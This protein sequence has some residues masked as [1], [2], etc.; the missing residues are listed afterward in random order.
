MCLTC[1]RHEG[2]EDL[3]EERQEVEDVVA[4]RGHL[5]LAALLI[6]VIC[7]TGANSISLAF[8]VAAEEAN[9]FAHVTRPGSC[10]RV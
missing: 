7:N 6:V 3:P 1:W 8:G 9:A 2:E 4:A 5:R 10:V